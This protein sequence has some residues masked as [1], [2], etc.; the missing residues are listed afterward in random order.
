MGGGCTL[1]E[2]GQQKRDGSTLVYY[3]PDLQSAWEA[4]LQLG[5]AGEGASSELIQPIL[6]M[7]DLSALSLDV[8]VFSSSA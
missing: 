5:A 8:I 6:T 7:T 1:G 2:A 4:T 3:S